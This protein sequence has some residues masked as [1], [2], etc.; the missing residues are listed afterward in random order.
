M[1]NYDYAI[2][3][4]MVNFIILLILIVMALII[5]IGA[6]YALN[7]KDKEIQRLESELNFYKAISYDYHDKLQ[8]SLELLNN[9]EQVLLDRVITETSVETVE[10]TSV[11]TEELPIITD[12]ADGAELFDSSKV[13]VLVPLECSGRKITL[14][15]QE[16]RW[17]AQMLYCEHRG[18]CWE[19]QVLTC[20]AIIN[21]CNINGGY[22]YCLHNS[23]CFS[24]ADFFETVEPN[25]MQY[26]VL[27]YVI[28]GGIIDN[29]IYFRANYYHDFGTPVC[30]CD[31][32]YFS[33]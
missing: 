12:S 18:A 33:N 23:V 26:D 22:D 19:G 20:S 9:C 7:L 11:E 3:R 21:Y 30:S 28:N 17:I 1:D 14:S 6:K 27:D 8:N 10:D 4:L 29:V 16:Y 13:S 2:R 32:H 5:V 15:E 24:P 31:N 25:Q